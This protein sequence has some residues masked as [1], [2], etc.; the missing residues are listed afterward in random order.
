[1]T[2]QLEHANLTVADPDATAAWMQR[3]FGW[4]IRWQGATE[5][6]LRAIHVG[7]GASYIALFAPE[8][9]GTPATGRY[10]TIGAMNHLG[11]VVDDLDAV[12]AR[13]GERR[14]TYAKSFKRSSA[15]PII[16]S[17]SFDN[18]TS[19]HATVIEVTCRDQ[20]GLLY[21]I[22]RALSEMR[23]G[24][25]TARI[26]TIGDVVVDTF[27]VKSGGT[28]V[29]DADHLAETERAVLHAIENK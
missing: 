27:Y 19:A 7:T 3:T 2:A 15:K 8:G 16:P 13:V 5:S 11:V 12:E 25:S 1:M 28:K 20:I 26:Q 18:E 6:G 10:A 17:V 4:Y 21:R 9:Q 22:S 29:S 14:R 24:I 23:I